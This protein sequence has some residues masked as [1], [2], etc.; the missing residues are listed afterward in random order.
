MTFSEEALSNIVAITW[1]NV[2]LRFVWSVFLHYYT[3]E[4]LAVGY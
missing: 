4:K 2:N 1:T 3:N